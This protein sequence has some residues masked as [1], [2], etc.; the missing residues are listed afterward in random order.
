MQTP[1]SM[2]SCSS[3]ALDLP[4]LSIPVVIIAAS[5]GFRFPIEAFLVEVETSV[6]AAAEVTERL[7]VRTAENVLLCREGSSLRSRTERCFLRRL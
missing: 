1:R 4:T 5:F 3:A 6:D 7:E 2:S